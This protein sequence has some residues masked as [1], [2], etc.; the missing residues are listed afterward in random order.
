MKEGG[1]YSTDPDEI[2]Q[3]VERENMTGLFTEKLES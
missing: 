2:A 1:L 3:R